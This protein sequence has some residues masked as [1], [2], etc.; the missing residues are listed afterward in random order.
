MRYR[1]KPKPEE[2][3][4][5]EDAVEITDPRFF[6]D[7]LTDRKLN[8]LRLSRDVHI[9]LALPATIDPDRKAIVPVEA[10]QAVSVSRLQGYHYGA[11]LPTETVPGYYSLAVDPNHRLYV[12]DDQLLAKLASLTTAAGNLRVSLQEATIKQ[13][14]DVQDHWT[15]SVVLLPSAAQT[16]SGAGSDVD[17]GRFLYAEVCV[18]VTAVSGTNPV[19]NVYVEGKDRYTGKY[20]TLLS[21]E[22]ISSVQ[23]LWGTI[24]MLAFTYLRV[25]WT[26]SGT[27]PSFTFS[28]SMEAKS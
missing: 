1:F 7:L 3:V 28:V 2:A 5:L 17:V 18:D 14:V 13:P 8:R 22:N 21:F 12:V 4:R 9:A 26:I 20:K 16:A 10:G 19:L 25:R 11:S 27:S 23:T 15:E 6:L 24:T